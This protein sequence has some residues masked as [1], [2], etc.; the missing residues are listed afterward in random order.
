M[1]TI[2]EVNKILDNNLFAK[3]DLFIFGK[4]KQNYYIGW[5]EGLQFIKNVVEEDESSSQCYIEFMIDCMLK[6]LTKE[7]NSK[8]SD[9]S[10]GWIEGYIESLRWF[11]S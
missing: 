5:Q 4:K 8:V 7:N 9:F 3:Y 11:L 10:F 2:F 6:K 1:K